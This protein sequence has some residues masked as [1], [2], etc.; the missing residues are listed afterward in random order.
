MRVEGISSRHTLWKLSWKVKVTISRFIFGPILIINFIRWFF[1]LPN[2]IWKVLLI[3]ISDGITCLFYISLVLFGLETQ[4]VNQ[5]LSISS[6]INFDSEYV[7]LILSIL[8]NFD[9]MSKVAY[10]SLTLIS[11][12]FLTLRQPQFFMFTAENSPSV[13]FYSPVNFSYQN[14]FRVEQPWK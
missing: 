12:C 9:D 11:L 13:N 8:S 6:Q 4:R 3:D 14:V 7:I 10:L 1:K 5:T 2:N